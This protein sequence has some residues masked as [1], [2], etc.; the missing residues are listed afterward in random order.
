MK[1]IAI[2]ALVYILTSCMTTN[3]SNNERF[4][5]DN[6]DSLQVGLTKNIIIG[7]LKIPKINVE[8][9]IGKE[10]IGVYAKLDS[11]DLIKIETSNEC[12]ISAIKTI[13]VTADNIYILDAVKEGNILIFNRKGMFIKRITVVSDP[14]KIS[15]I[16][17]IAYNNI[18]NELIVYH[19]NYFSHYSSIGELI[20]KV[21]IP[22]AAHSFETVNNG[23]LIKTTK[24]IVNDSLKEYSKCRLFVLDENFKLKYAIKHINPSSESYM[25]ATSKNT[26]KFNDKITVT[27]PFNDTIFEFSKNKLYP[28]LILDFGSKGIP[29][30]LFNKDNYIDRLKKNDY[31]HYVGDYVENSTH[32]FL[33]T[34]NLHTG[35][36]ISIFRDKLSGNLIY[37]NSYEYPSSYFPCATPYTSIDDTFVSI[38]KITPEFVNSK[39]GKEYCKNNNIKENDNPI[40]VFYKLKHF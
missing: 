7:N 15:K 2:A 17:K 39:F 9:M 11:V 23:Y 29:K 36:M 37:G 28:K 13:L 25:S 24:G 22:I 19:G 33:V 34:L 1:K 12:L 8:S 30:D 27:F 18:T 21:K 14:K 35:D 10:R 5:Q 6:I 26:S 3:N 38:I 31:H 20:K 4:N 40:L 32:E 16:M